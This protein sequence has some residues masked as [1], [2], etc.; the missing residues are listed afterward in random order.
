MNVQVAFNI[1]SMSVVFKQYMDKMY[2]YTCLQT[3]V[4]VVCNISHTHTLTQLDL[5]AL[6]ANKYSMTVLIYF[7]PF[8]LT[9]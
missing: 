3:E 1:V 4:Y 9:Y 7:M 2:I 8:L 5:T 6:V